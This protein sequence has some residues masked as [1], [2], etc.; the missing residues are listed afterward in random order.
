MVV[1]NGDQDLNGMYDVAVVGAG[2]AGL[3]AATS[4]CQLGADVLVIE[5]GKH[6]EGRSQDHG[7]DVVCGV[8]GAG[9][10]SDGKFSFYPSAT[11]LWSIQPAHELLAGYGW[12][13]ELLTAEGL[14]VPDFPKIPWPRRAEGA[15]ERKEYPSFYLPIAQRMKILRSL[16]SRLETCMRTQCRV[17]AFQHTGDHVRLLTETGDV[18]A[19]ARRVVVALGRYG[20]LA[21]RRSLNDSDF[22]F[23]RVEVGVR[24][25]QP[26]ED[27]IL[28]N[29]SC[30][31]PKLIGNIGNGRSWRTFCCCRD[32]LVVPTS[33]AGI[34]SVSGRADCPPTGRSNV[35]LLARFSEP[36]AGM[37]A[38]R[39]LLYSRPSVVPVVESMSK[40]MD[41]SG[42]IHADNSRALQ[43]LGGDTARHV[44]RGLNDLAQFTGRTLASAVLYAPAIEGV[45]LYPQSCQD[46]HIP[47][48]PIFVAGDL[49]GKFRGLT[50]A[51]ISG[52]A[53][54]SSAALEALNMTSKEKKWQVSS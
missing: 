52:Y 14:R 35:G 22:V 49:T 47:G 33:S 9:L 29:D 30:L 41:R 26:S 1:A 31:D 13:G 5:Q 46:M 27:F 16:S 37:A 10:Y 25:E 23:R 42:H 28:S 32:G 51:L 18:I 21:L 34:C 39:D 8:G 48:R 45:G 40:L 24:I 36:R 15:I 4:A 7:T 43:S 12:L 50:A 19:E 11:A 6:I 20:P 54:G 44:L 38:W 3:A 2:P 17:A 53:A